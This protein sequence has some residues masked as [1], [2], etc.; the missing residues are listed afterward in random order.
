[1]RLPAPSQL[2]RYIFRQLTIALIAVTGGLVALIWLTQS[3]R[4]VELVVNRGLSMGVFLQ[5]TGLLIPNFV[6]VI[7][8]ITIFVVAQF[9]Y[10]R[11]AGD[12]E[13]TVMRAAGLS[14]VALA[15]PAL[16]LAALVVA[17]CYVL[18][19][20]LVPVSYS[21]FREYQFEIRNRLA[22]F[23]LQE[24]VF[25]QVSDEMTVYV[26]S[27]DRDGTL[28][29][30]L[31][32][33]ARQKNSRAT[34]LSETG[35]LVNGPAGPR[36]LLQ[37]GSRQEI[38]RVNGRLNVLTFAENSIDLSS[39]SKNG[40][41]RYRDA[42]EMSIPE[43][44]NPPP[45]I[46]ARDVGKLQVEA[47]RRLSAPLTAASF[48]LVAL[49]SVLTGAF[50]RHGNVLRPLAAVLSVVALLAVGLGGGEPGRPADRADSADLD[51]RRTLPGLVCGLG[52]V[53][54]VQPSAARSRMPSL[55][56]AARLTLA[57]PEMRC[58]AACR[59]AGAARVAEPGAAAAPAR[60]RLRMMAEQ[61]AGGAARPRRTPPVPSLRRPSGP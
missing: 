41:Q 6:A 14:P 52:A 59:A 42:A 3:L 55:T 17:G 45:S 22:A 51:A 27:R 2:D 26:R 11:L 53:R 16:T 19:V 34:I 46:A 35:R 7:L 15:R 37:N 23:L 32:E 50:R 13:L 57:M 5:L 1:M 28:R 48:A 43:L 47:H 44:L 25:T 54:A 33:D 9:V 4:F 29:G 18:N 60:R 21:A 58:W 38:D 30:I 8:P 10:Q 40:E 49:L 12:R 24:G 61:A 56:R 39:N 31:V 36:V 20:W